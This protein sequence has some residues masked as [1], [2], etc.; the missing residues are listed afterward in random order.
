MKSSSPLDFLKGERPNLNP[1]LLELN[2]DD[3]G[4]KQKL[5]ELENHQHKRYSSVISHLE[6]L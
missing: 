2:Y 4:V 6:D 3:S 1:L 5:R